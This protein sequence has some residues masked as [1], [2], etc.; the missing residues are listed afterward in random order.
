[1]RSLLVEI[2]LPALVL[3]IV[4]VVWSL[5]QWAGD[6]SSRGALPA[7]HRAAAR[8][9]SP[10][11]APADALAGVVANGNLAAVPVDP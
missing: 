3:T 2:K 7:G 9:A 8:I 11:Y 1:M 4:F 10:S 5:G 6:E